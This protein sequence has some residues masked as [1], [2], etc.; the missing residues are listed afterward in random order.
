[1]SW[2]SDYSSDTAWIYVNT[3]L[4]SVNEELSFCL[5]GKKGSIVHLFNEFH[6]TIS[7][8]ENLVYA[9]AGKPPE[10]ASREVDNLPATQTSSTESSFCSCHADDDER[11]KF[12][13]HF[14]IKSG[15]FWN[16]FTQQDVFCHDLARC[17]MR[18]SIHISRKRE[19]DVEQ[20]RTRHSWLV[21]DNVYKYWRRTALFFY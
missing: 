19:D 12:I 17:S 3:G 1:M 10:G 11:H 9:Q 7:F 6:L 18:L 14:N 13:E 5:D 15:S 4:Q 8:F 2:E 20:T 16:D 21:K